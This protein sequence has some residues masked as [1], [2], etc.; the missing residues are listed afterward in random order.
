MST[1]TLNHG[2]FFLLGLLRHG[3]GMLGKF[4][5]FSAT[6]SVDLDFET[7]ICGHLL[8]TNLAGLNFQAGLV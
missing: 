4:P 5:G 2:Q 8:A 1:N 6:V 7:V 3:R